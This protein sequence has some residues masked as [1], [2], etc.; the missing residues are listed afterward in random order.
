MPAKRR[1]A[2][3]GHRRGGA[4]R[5]VNLKYLVAYYL[6]R[7]GFRAVHLDLDTAVLGDPRPHLAAGLV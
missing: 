4:P 2:G 5:A 6:V 1:A 3:V 7:A